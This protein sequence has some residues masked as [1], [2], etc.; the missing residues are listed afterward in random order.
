[1]THIHN[2][3][4]MHTLIHVARYFLLAMVLTV[5]SSSLFSN[6]K[7]IKSD[8]KHLAE[9]NILIDSL[10]NISNNL[11]SIQP[12]EA[13]R[14]ALKAVRLSEKE[15]SME[16]IAKSRLNLAEVY[17][18]QRNFS[19]LL[20]TLNPLLPAIN[21]LNNDTLA[22]DI[23]N[24]IGIAHFQ[25]RHDT[26]P[27][28][29]FIKGLDKSRS[30]N[31]LDSLSGSLKSIGKFYISIDNHKRAAD[32][33]NKSA[34]VDS[35]TQ[36]NYGLGISWFYLGKTAFSSQ[37]QEEAIRYF[38]AALPLLSDSMKV[39]AYL[40]LAKYYFDNQISLSKKYL[41]KADSITYHY[42][43]L[44]IHF[45]IL[46]LHA[47]LS[48][49]N[50][51][52]SKAK[53]YLK[54]AENLDYHDA[55]T[56]AET[57]VFIGKKLLIDNNHTEAIR[58]FS[59]AIN[60]TQVSY[61]IKSKAAL[62]LADAYKIAGEKTKESEMLRTYVALMDSTLAE[63]LREER[64]R[65]NSP[66]NQQ[67]LERKI[68]L[69]QKESK[70]QNLIIEKEKA[71]KTN[72]IVLALILTPLLF[73]ILLLYRDRS[74]ANKKLRA[75]NLQ[76]NQQVDELSEMVHCLSLS[77]QQL[78][79]ANTTKEKLF[80][81]VA[82][83]LKS[84]LISLKTLLY[85][86]NSETLNPPNPYQQQ[87]RDI[88]IN[89][90]TIIDLLNNLLFWALSQKE[91]IS[92]LPREFNLRKTAETDLILAQNIATQKNILIRNKIPPELK[93]VTDK[94]MYLF[95]LRNLLSNALKFTPPKGEISLSIKENKNEIILIVKDTGPGIGI[96][97]QNTIFDLVKTDKSEK[98]PEEG[99][100]LGMPLSQE[101]AKIM[102]GTLT[103]TSSP[104]QGSIFM[105]TTPGNIN[106]TY[107]NEH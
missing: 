46:L 56:L 31:E 5:F 4:Q 90:N 37:K 2:Y 55:E 79:K 18:H 97:K 14:I 62:G 47:K 17:R 39:K 72:F 3:P 81:I 92:L 45:E 68:D 93:I 84:P 74:L 59:Q 42:N 66:L 69:Y 32:F 77:K 51:D 61:F 19:A 89:L 22:A 106:N 50:K 58:S 41:Q 36:N 8:P 71:K 38:K 75:Q 65:L 73:F 13:T 7:K 43:D 86:L 12:E 67:N 21:E 24:N 35:I 30:K 52:Y 70:I 82:H 6:E 104:G 20:E 10:I 25:L 87:F 15:G 1:M 96:E 80:S 85:S 23:L 105:L 76:I 83:D 29:A 99:T 16:K 9:Q 11:I 40:D 78:Q 107:D 53:E 63:T 98:N 34:A 94:N 101:F 49:E 28:H 60:Q 27:L 95:V 88:E 57:Y 102:G 54:N 48:A 103:V 33:F 64:N 44:D 91:A 100:G 26:I